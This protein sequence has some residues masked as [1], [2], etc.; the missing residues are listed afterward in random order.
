MRKAITFSFLFFYITVAFS[1]PAKP[2]QWQNLLLKNGRTVSVR[3]AGDENSRFYTDVE[4]NKYNED[5]SSYTDAETFP[6][7]LP[8]SRSGKIEAKRMIRLKNNQAQAVNIGKKKGLILLVNFKDVKLNPTHTMEVFDKL[9]NQEQYKE[10]DIQGSVHDYFLAQ[11]NGKFDLT[12]D[13]KGVYELSHDRSYYGGNVKIGNQ[14]ADRRPGEMIAE[15]CKLA[16][17]DTDFKKY[18]WNQDGEV[19]QVFVIYAGKGEADKGGSETIWPHEWD[20]EDSDYG[21]I[22]QYVCLRPRAKWRRRAVRN[23]YNLS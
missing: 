10:G 8:K 20:L 2:N 9:A 3:L 15:A 17:K 13:V 21:R 22:Y 6:G 14:Y 4:G 11:S 19:D 16:A 7:S 18:D 23:R 12:F 5:G 1:G